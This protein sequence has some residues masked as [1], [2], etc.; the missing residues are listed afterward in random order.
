MTNACFYLLS[1]H[2]SLFAC[3]QRGLIDAKFQAKAFAKAKLCLLILQF[4]LWGSTFM[5]SEPVIGEMTKTESIE[6]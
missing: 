1:C 3:T 2:F 5:N 6:Q 4:N